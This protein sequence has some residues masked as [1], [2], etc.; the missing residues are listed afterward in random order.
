ME[1]HTQDKLGFGRKFEVANGFPE[2]EAIFQ[3]VYSGVLW[4]AFVEAAR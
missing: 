3:T 1:D 2:V 4:Q